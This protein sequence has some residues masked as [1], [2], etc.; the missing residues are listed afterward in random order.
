[1]ETERRQKLLDDLPEDYDVDEQIAKTQLL[2]QE[3]AGDFISSEK[4][5][6]QL[7]EEAKQIEQVVGLLPSIEIGLFTAGRISYPALQERL[8]W[9]LRV[10]VQLIGHL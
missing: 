8:R 9:K 5:A 7:L 2:E 1:M 4:I 6:E 10:R 3:L